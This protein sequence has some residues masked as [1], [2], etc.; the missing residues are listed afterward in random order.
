MN[1]LL[2]VMESRLSQEE[3]AMLQSIHDPKTVIVPPGDACMNMCVTPD[4]EIRLYGAEDKKHPDD[5]GRKVYYASTDCGLSWKKHY[6]EHKAL[7][8][9]AYSR[10][11]GR[12]MSVFP[13]AYRPEIKNYFNESG[14]WAVFN[15]VGFDCTKNRFVKVCDERAHILK[16]PFYLES[17]DRWFI[18]GQYRT[19]DTGKY[20][21]VVFYSDDNGETW[22]E[23]IIENTAPRFEITPP[24]KG[25]RWQQDSCEPSVVELANGELVMMVRTSQDYHYIYRSPDKGYTWIGP[26]RSNFHGTITMP[27][28]HKLHDGRIVFF[29]CNTEPMPELDHNR[30]WPLLGDDVKQGIWE[31]V[32]TNRDANHLAISEDNMQSFIGFRELH[33]NTIRNYADFRSVGGLDSRDKS[34]HQGQI[35]E[36][37]FNKIM[38]HFGQNAASRKVVI[39]D[40]N[41]LYEKDR[42]E[43]FRYGLQ[44][45]STQMYIKSNLGNFRGFSGHCAYNRTDGALLVPD[46][47]GNFKEVL[48]LARI[49]D[50]RLVCK[51]QGVVWNFPA[52]KKGEVTVELKVLSS[53]VNVC[54]TDHWYNP[55]DETVKDKAH[56]AV[57]IENT[58]DWVTLGI[59]FDTEKKKANVT[60]GTEQY[61]IPIYAEAPNGL[62][63]LHIQT[64]AETQDFKGTLIRKLQ[65][66]EFNTTSQII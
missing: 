47:E 43:D 65:K 45:V 62:S 56:V 58:I 51:K 53:G 27:I 11:T 46:P 3:K 33:L 16:L 32:F 19:K 48:Q 14:T 2:N 17:S 29:W 7:G 66:T 49:E 31:D 4:G 63:Y 50:P 42:N 39:V 25:A 22:T 64:L 37:P 35:I 30:T 44:N 18:L 10:K 24:H 12:Y 8:Q 5:I 55:S 6:M 61:E 23:R 26:E 9:A 13:L 52:D 20:M 40:L 28:L 41:W 57:K 21:P 36:L 38:V 15:D 60:C 59:R 54:L 1:N 34:I